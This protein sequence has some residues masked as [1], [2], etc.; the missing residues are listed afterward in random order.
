MNKRAMKRI[1]FGGFK[2]HLSHLRPNLMWDVFI[3][4][5]GLKSLCLVSYLNS[6]CPFWILG[7][8]SKKYQ[9]HSGGKNL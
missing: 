8:I 3:D 5:F 1:T 9:L 6:V 4:I 7:V 2:S